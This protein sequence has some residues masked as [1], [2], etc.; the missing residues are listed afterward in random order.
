MFVRGR[1]VDI[2]INMTQPTEAETTAVDRETFARRGRNWNTTKS[3]TVQQ[4]PLV[5]FGI[6]II[7][8]SPTPLCVPSGRFRL[9]V[10]SVGVDFDTLYYGTGNCTVRRATYQEG[11]VNDGC[12]L[13]KI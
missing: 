13:G 8:K 9:F 3:K 1:C 7:Q 10:R 12:T 2:S 11:P 6:S 5:F 4:A